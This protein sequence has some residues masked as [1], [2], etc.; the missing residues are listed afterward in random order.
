MRR[1][2]KIERSDRIDKVGADIKTVVRYGLK[3]RK[4]EF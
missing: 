1:A 3:E 2:I 4:E